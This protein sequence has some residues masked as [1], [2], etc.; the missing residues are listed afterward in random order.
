MATVN[1]FKAVFSLFDKVVV[2]FVE[3]GEMLFLN[4]VFEN[5]SLGGTKHVVEMRPKQA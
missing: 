1:P 2:G 4:L 3:K 5:K